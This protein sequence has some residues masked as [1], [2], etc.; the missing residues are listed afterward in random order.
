MATAMGPERIDLSWTAPSENG[1]DDI[2][3]YMIQYADYGRRREWG[4]GSWTDLW[5]ATPT[6][7]T[8]PS[9]TMEMTRYPTSAIRL[10]AGEPSGNTGWRR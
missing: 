5:W 6:A 7:P 10:T 3:G 1:G 9:A 4:T 2:T 8:L